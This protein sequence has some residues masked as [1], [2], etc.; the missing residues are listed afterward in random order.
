VT[1]S[2]QLA[3]HVFEPTN[4]STGRPTCCWNWR[5]TDCDWLPV[6]VV[7]DEAPY[8]PAGPAGL[9]PRQVRLD[10]PV[11]VIPVVGADADEVVR[12]AVVDLYLKL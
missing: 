2:V 5:Q 6:E 10:V 12:V 8:L 1:G 4:P 3:C 7:D 9:A 11:D